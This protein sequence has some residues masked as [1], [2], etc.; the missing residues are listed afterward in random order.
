MIKKRIEKADYEM[1][2]AS[3]FDLIIVNDNLEVAKLEA[4]KAICDFIKGK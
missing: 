3:N 2:F 4:E 1:G